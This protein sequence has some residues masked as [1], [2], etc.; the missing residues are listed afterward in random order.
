MMSLRVALVRGSHKPMIEKHRLAREAGCGRR[1][2][3]GPGAGL[4][5]PTG[6]GRSGSTSFAAKASAAFGDRTGLSGHAPDQSAGRRFAAA[7]LPSLRANRT[8]QRH[9]FAGRGRRPWIFARSREKGTAERPPAGRRPVRAGV[10]I[11]SRIAAVLIAWAC[12]SFSPVGVWGETDAPKSTGSVPTN[13]ELLEKL[14]RDAVDGVLEGAPLN[15]NDTLHVRI[16]GR[17]RLEWVVENYLLARLATDVA[18]VYVTQA[19]RDTAVGGKLGPMGRRER[20]EQMAREAEAAR[21]ERFDAV[22]PA[23]QGFDEG[24]DPRFESPAGGDVANDDFGGAQDT[25]GVEAGDEET[26]LLEEQ[27]GQPASMIEA[28]TIQVDAPPSKVETESRGDEEEALR[29]EREAQQIVGVAPQTGKLL[30]FRIGELEVRYPRRWRGSL[31]GSAMVERSARAVVF[32]RLLDKTDGRVLWADSGRAAGTDVVGQKLLA[33]LEEAE[34][35]GERA[36]SPSG[37]LGRVVE[38]IVVSGVVVG[39]VFLFYSSRT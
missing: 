26:S 38:P 13:L 30:E 8:S 31:F 10:V 16:L 11:P 17:H 18:A 3:S 36:E 5:G 37:G 15:P 19:K 28:E 32:F 21:D 4:A 24:E 9:L 29:A 7:G 27:E 23:S 22:P 25:L 1:G 14:V 33:D 20:F 2:F 6:F 35:G 39:L 34:E 12:L